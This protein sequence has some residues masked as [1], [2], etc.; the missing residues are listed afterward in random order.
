MQSDRAWAARPVVSSGAFR[1]DQAAGLAVDVG[2]FKALAA[3]SARCARRGEQL[4]AAA[5]A[6]R[7]LRLCGGDLGLVLAGLTPSGG[8]DVAMILERERLR[9]LY[10]DLLARLADDACE[11]QDPAAGQDYA[12]RLL[13]LDP[14]RD[15]AQRLLRRLSRA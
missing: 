14:G 3:Q 5:L 7:A 6:E 10:L 15:D 2:H 11:R 9:G 4:A 1:P 8:G 13:A 12:L